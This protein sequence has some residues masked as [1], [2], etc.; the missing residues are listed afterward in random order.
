MDPLGESSK[1]HRKGIGGEFSTLVSVQ[2]EHVTKFHK[3]IWSLLR[4]T[5]GHYM[6]FL[7]LFVLQLIPLTT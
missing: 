5:T 2:L 1:V 4:V 6:S 7:E 3:R